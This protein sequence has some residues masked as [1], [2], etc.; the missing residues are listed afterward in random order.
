MATHRTEDSGGNAAA[1]FKLSTYNATGS[2]T[3]RKCKA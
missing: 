2:F 1:A 3:R